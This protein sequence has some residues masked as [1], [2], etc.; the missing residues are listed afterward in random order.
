M[1]AVVC[2]A[3]MMGCAIAY[4][5][6]KNNFFESII[7]VDTNKKNLHAAKNFFSQSSIQF[8]KVD[9]SDEMQM[10]QVLR[11]AD[12][13]VSAVPYYF[14]YRLTKL[15]IK[16]N[17][18]FVDLGGNT[19]VVL[20]QRKLNTH[21]KKHSVTI[22]PDCGLAPGLVSVI[23]KDIVDQLDSVDTVSLRVG[24]VP[25]DPKPP[26]N[27]QIV[28]SP[29]GLINEYSEPAVILDEGHIK[30]KPSL[31]ELESILFPEP[32]GEME[33]F[34]TSG[35]CSTLPYTFQNKIKYLNYKTIRYPGHCDQIKTIFRLGLADQKK[36]TIGGCKIAPR[37]LLIELLSRYVPSTG[38]DVVLLKAEGQG[39]KDGKNRTLAYT[40][41]EYADEKTG[42]SAMMRTTGF[43]AAITA[44]MICKEI[45]QETGVF[46]SEE[47]IPP[48]PFFSYLAKRGIHLDKK[49]T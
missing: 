13:A 10:K 48:K 3:G 17:C 1:K 8:R 20:K 27:Y 18:H 49:V 26:L 4:D 44:Y 12:I 9:V 6:Y 19:D 5:L 45:I 16:A 28:F 41:I 21:A 37:D 7:M 39:L 2:G 33:A 35:G 43:P 46:C 25:V 34:L 42:L 14:N 15:A 32:F 40:M 47:V 29:H 11:S 22:I 23:T 36:Y 38:K 30:T 31:T 24:G